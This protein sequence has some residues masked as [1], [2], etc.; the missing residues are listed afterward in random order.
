MVATF[1]KAL[2]HQPP[3]T[4]F[5]NPYRC[6]GIVNNQRKHYYH[7]KSNW[8]ILR[9]VPRL[10]YSHIYAGSREPNGFIILGQKIVTPRYFV[11]MPEGSS[12]KPPS[13]LLV[14][15][16]PFLSA[17][18]LLRVREEG[19]LRQYSGRHLTGCVCDCPLCIKDTWI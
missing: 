10:S 3:T 17:R 5:A 13:A 18:T 15:L 11:M 6:H 8:C 19:L 9:V 16:D 12:S 7:Q 1:P 2:L 4:G 14:Y